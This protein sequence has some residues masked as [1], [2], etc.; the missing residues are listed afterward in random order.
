VGSLPVITA[1]YLIE[2]YGFVYVF[3]FQGNIR[4]NVRRKFLAFFASLREMALVKA[5]PG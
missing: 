3:W 5:C 4:T 1:T 2:H